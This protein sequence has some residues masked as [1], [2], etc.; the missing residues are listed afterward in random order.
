MLSSGISLMAAKLKLF[1]SDITKA[2]VLH[3]SGMFFAYLQWGV[4]Y[5]ETDLRL[6][7]GRTMNKPA[8]AAVLWE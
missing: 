1:Y 4:E 8:R 6:N 2:K 7:G 5:C 3:T